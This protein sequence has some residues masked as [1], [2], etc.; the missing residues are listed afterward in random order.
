MEEQR[1]LIVNADDFGQSPGVNRGIIEAHE[2]GIVTSTSLMVRWPAAADAAEYA[3]GR[4]DLAVG[5][6]L[7]LVEWVYRDGGW[8]HLYEV[9]PA[10]DERLVR[11]E[12][13]RQ[14]EAFRTFLGREP[15]HLDSHQHVH[16]KGPAREI[17]LD[18]AQALGI[19]VRHLSPGIRYVGGFYGQ[20]DNGR[21][22]PD[23][24]S[25]ANLVRILDTVTP[26]ITELGCHPGRSG[27][28]DVVYGAERDLEVAT[29]C[30]LQVRAAL[31]ARRIVLCSFRSA[32][33][34]QAIAAGQGRA[35]DPMETDAG[36]GPR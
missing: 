36:S 4:P 10:D 17:V 15:S 19:P 3:R 33:V 24:I 23:G 27:D 32:P 28:T 26:G 5:L 31:A 29:L 14:V 22:Y 21:P 30:D 6:H 16:R 9:V 8:R 20:F 7:D 25:V 13:E 1:Y 2:R 11:Q 35:G 18:L 12:I 34:R